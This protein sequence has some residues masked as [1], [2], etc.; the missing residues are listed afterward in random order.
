MD[1]TLGFHPLF[2]PPTAGKNL[3]SLFTSIPIWAICL[4]VQ[5]D[6]LCESL[7]N[8]N[9]LWFCDPY[10]FIHASWSRQK[11][12]YPSSTV[13]TEVFTIFFCTEIYTC[14]TEHRFCITIQ[15]V[16]ERPGVWDLF[17]GGTGRLLQHKIL[18]AQKNL[19]YSRTFLFPG[20]HKMLISCLG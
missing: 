12:S 15:G 1:F 4:R 3:Q 20:L 7:P 13:G 11:K 17:R 2:C 14:H 10:Y 8:Q 9:I 18:F 5:L 19:F 6:D 16:R